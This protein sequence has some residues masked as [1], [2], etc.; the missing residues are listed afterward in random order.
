MDLPMASGQ[1]D[2]DA[3]RRNDANYLNSLK[4][5]PNTSYILVTARGEVA[6]KSDH[7]YGQAPHGGLTPPDLAHM[8]AEQL[9]ELSH[10]QVAQLPFSPQEPYYLGKYG[11][12]SYLALRVEAPSQQLEEN[13]Q[14]CFAPLR[15]VAGMLE[16]YQGELAAAAVALATWD[17]N[18][19]F[20]ERCGASL[21]LACAGWEK[22]C[23]ACA[24]ITYPRTDPAIIVAITDDAERLLLIHG[25]T[26]QPGRYSVV[27]GF[28]E[29]GESL[30]AA[31]AREALEET[32]IKISQA[33]YCSSQ[34]WPFPR[35]LMFAFT[36]RAGGQQEPKADM[37]EVGHAFWVSREE[38]TQLVLEGK[39]IVPGRASSGH[40]LV[41]A[42]Y[43][44][45]LPQ[46]R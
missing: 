21:K 19:K 31:V 3:A 11:E 42:W 28:V 18:T 45:E 32:G 38:F 34:P 14:Y 29:A 30:E 15:A 24:H 16:P 23:T 5:S 9:L 27:A 20:C 2:R 4:D 40:A 36:A 10:A 7:V 12:K 13:R 39:V 26:W 6:I 8:E 25:A 33:S 22:H 37:Q 41:R 17:K 46:P 1:F 44:R 35:S 43:G